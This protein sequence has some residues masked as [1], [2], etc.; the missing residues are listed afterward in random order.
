MRR[1]GRAFLT[2][3]VVLTLTIN[4]V[5]IILYGRQFYAQCNENENL[6][7]LGG[8]LSEGS[9][10]AAENCLGAGDSAQAIFIL[11][12]VFIIALLLFIWVLIRHYYYQHHSTVARS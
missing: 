8:V 10:Q 5:L 9:A 4:L 2:V 7:S 1:F 6:G 12:N 11:V 3:S